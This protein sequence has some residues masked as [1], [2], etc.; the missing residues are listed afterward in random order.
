MMEGLFI[1][2]KMLNSS[3]SGNVFLKWINNKPDD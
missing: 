1:H 2:Q 3:F